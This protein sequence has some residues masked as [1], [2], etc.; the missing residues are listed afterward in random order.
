MG[1]SYVGDLDDVEARVSE[2][3]VVAELAAEEDA[4]TDKIELEGS[5][6]DNTG[7]GRAEEAGSGDS[8]RIVDSGERTEE[9]GGWLDRTESVSS[10]D[11]T[12]LVCCAGSD[13]TTGLTGAL[14]FVQ[15]A[16]VVVVV[17]SF[18]PFFPFP[19]VP[20]PLTVVPLA[21]FSPCFP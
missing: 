20:F 16:F 11:G 19:S 2:G 7:I 3:V 13:V 4:E 5:A 8:D 1:T 10:V 14:G 21:T 18:L 17:F 15:G 6:E 9:G 12:D